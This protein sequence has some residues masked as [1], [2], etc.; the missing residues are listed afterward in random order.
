MSLF[1]S[2][3]SSGNVMWNM[4]ADTNRSTIEFLRMV[5][6]MRWTILETQASRTSVLAHLVVRPSISSGSSAMR[7]KDLPASDLCLLNDAIGLL[8]EPHLPERM[9][10]L[11]G[12]D[13][14]HR[15][16]KPG[17]SFD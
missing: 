15:L 1:Q 16:V 17:S 9:R 4:T 7:R 12:Q 14:H 2:E 11:P 8:V 13:P 10:R 5:A 3:N 6:K